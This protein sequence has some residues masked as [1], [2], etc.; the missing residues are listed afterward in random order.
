MVNDRITVRN[1]ES[2][3]VVVAP[4]GS[5]TGALGRSV[6]ILLRFERNVLSCAMTMVNHPSPQDC[7][8]HP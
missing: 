4:Q 1:Q 5:D 6:Y 2:S 7:E 8:C 3:R